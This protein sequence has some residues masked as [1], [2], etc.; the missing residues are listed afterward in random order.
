MLY[1]VGRQF[2]VVVDPFIFQNFVATNL[3]ASHAIFSA[4]CLVKFIILEKLP[5]LGTY[6]HSSFILA[7]L[8]MENFFVRFSL[9]ESMIGGKI[10]LS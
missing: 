9:Q 6:K 10:S 3:N 5:Y 8:N 1:E 2:Y 7:A 4:K